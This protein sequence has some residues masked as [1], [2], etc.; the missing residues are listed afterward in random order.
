[1]L[2][3][4]DTIAALAS[5]PGAAAR[6]IV[7]VSGGEAREAVARIFHPDDQERWD[8]AR[9][10]GRHPGRLAV[11]AFPESLVCDAYLWPTPRS[12]T[13]QPIVELH[14]PGSPVLAEAVLAALFR[15]GVRPARAGEF[16]LR[17]FLAGRLDLVRAEAVLGVID[18]EDHRELNLALGQLAG[19]LSNRLADV[20]GDLLSLLADLEAGLDF[21]EEDI[22]FVS[23]DDVLHRV[24]AARDA[25]DRMLADATDRWRDSPAARIV[26]AGLPNAG[27]STLFNRLAAA[28]HALVSPIAGTTRDWLTASV[29]WQG[30][31]VELVDTAGW[32]IPRDELSKAMHLVR[33]E[34]LDRADLVLWCTPA[35]LD[36]RHAEID[37]R[38]QRELQ[39]NQRYLLTITTKAD[40]DDSCRGDVP[41]ELRVCA[42]SGRGLTSLRSRL[43]SELRSDRAPARHMLGSTA[44]R[45]R[46][47]LASARDALQRLTEAAE[48]GFGDE[49]LS[50]ELRTALDG[51]AAV[52]GAVYSDD[53]L[54]VIFSRFCIGK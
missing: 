11:P 47:S 18:A 9:L 17:A 42:R 29:D 8:A 50:A 46:E 53:V 13:G 35:D 34:Q 10:A 43:M 21:V 36:P 54:D 5:A 4:D 51:L 49:I 28:E 16:T 40:L 39:E 48:A 6:A 41:H 7:R 12:Y 1:M 37:K 52:V 15:G 33:S 25:I 24:A 26:L 27:K 44:A 38:L 31:R 22:E 32:E 30:T 2:N 20:R 19:G 23:R 45:G 14:L 3:I